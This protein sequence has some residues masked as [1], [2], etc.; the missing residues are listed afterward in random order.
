M[1]VADD[2]EPEITLEVGWR[3]FA[4][5]LSLLILLT[6]AGILGAFYELLIYLA[7][8]L[9]PVELKLGNESFLRNG[10]LE[11]RICVAEWVKEDELNIIVISPENTL[12]YSGRFK[13]GSD[14]CMTVAVLLKETVEGIYTVAVVRRNTILSKTH[15]RVSD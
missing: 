14:N 2:E 1:L 8:I 7:P 12:L 4:L 9:H 5:V 10:M 15:F 3:S 6:I 13:R 11:L